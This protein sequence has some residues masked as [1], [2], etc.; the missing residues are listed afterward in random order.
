MLII[1][2]SVVIIAALVFARVY[3]P[4]LVEAYLAGKEEE[5]RLAEQLKLDREALALAA[6]VAHIASMN[7]LLAVAFGPADV[8]RDLIMPLD[9]DCEYLE[10]ELELILEDDTLTTSQALA[11]ISE[12][13]TRTDRG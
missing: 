3:G 2:A 1:F 6:Y 8:S 4:H 5:R 9:V 10:S 13:V 12:L 11:Q 7:Q